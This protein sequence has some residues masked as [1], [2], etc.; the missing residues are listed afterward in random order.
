MGQESVKSGPGSQ[1]G[2]VGCCEW[3]RKAHYSF[4]I[5]YQQYIEIGTQKAFTFRSKHASKSQS[6]KPGPQ[7]TKSEL[8]V[9]VKGKERPT[10]PSIYAQSVCM[11]LKYNA[12]KA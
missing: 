1:I 8:S 6:A 11:G 9:A 4:N 2:A 3:E 7:A 12:A 10:I 5:C